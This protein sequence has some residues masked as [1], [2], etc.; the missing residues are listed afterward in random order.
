MPATWVENYV[1]LAFRIERVMQTLHERRFIACY[2]G[3]SVWKAEEEAAPMRSPADLLRMAGMLGESLAAESLEL[4]RA[5]FLAKQLLAMETVCRVLC[6]ETLSLEEETSRCFDIRPTWTP[7]EQFEQMLALGETLLPGQGSAFDRMQA[8]TRRYT[9]PPEKSPLVLRFSQKALAEAR[10]RTH[11]IIALPDE[12]EV[13]VQTVT[14]R[15]GNLAFSRYLGNYRSR[16]EFNL[17]ASLDLSR[18]LEIMSHEGYPGHHV[19]GVLKERE[20]YRARGYVEQSLTLS[21]APQSVINE[22]LAM[23]AP[24]MIYIP[25]EEQAWLAEHIYPIA[26]IEPLTVDWDYMRQM[27]DVTMDAQGNAAFLLHE[28]RPEQEVRQYLMRHLMITEE[29][30]QPMLAYLNIPFNAA[31]VFSYT[32]G[33]RLLEPWLACSDRR[34]AFARLLTEALY[35]SQL[36]EDVPFSAHQTT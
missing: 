5:T 8:L 22:G 34:T 3:P 30:A 18:L 4:R 16:I 7:E 20:L 31:R 32:A 12:E 1:R 21:L 6:G 26:G 33:K 2:Y 28:G 13:S 27:F 17:D 23:L 35:P 36:A 14:N 11:E 19:E 10:R 29:E 9:L 24:S 15:P 25:D